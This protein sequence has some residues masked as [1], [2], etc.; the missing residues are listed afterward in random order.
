VSAWIN[1]A[2]LVAVNGIYIRFANSTA[3]KDPNPSLVPS[4]ETMGIILTQSLNRY[5]NKDSPKQLQSSRSNLNSKTISGRFLLGTCIYK[6]LARASTPRR[7][8]MGLVK[9]ILTSVSFVPSDDSGVTICFIY[10]WTQELGEEYQTPQSEN[11][12]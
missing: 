7:L 11:N 1:P 2:G 12:G 6:S 8:T 3:V 10:K 5:S 9:S 4:P